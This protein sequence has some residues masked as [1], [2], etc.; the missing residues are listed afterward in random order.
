MCIRDRIRKY[1]DLNLVTLIGSVRNTNR[2]AWLMQTYKPDIV[3][4]AAAHKLSLIHI[5]RISSGKSR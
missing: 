5:F 2:L 4:H 3:F 1:P